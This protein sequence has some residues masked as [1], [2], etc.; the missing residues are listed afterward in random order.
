MAPPGRYSTVFSLVH[1]FATTPVLMPL[2][3]KL[4]NQAKSLDEMLQARRRQHRT[5]LSSL[6]KVQNAIGEIGGNAG[7]GGG[8][9]AGGGASAGALQAGADPDPDVAIAIAEQ[10]VSL[11]SNNRTLFTC[12]LCSAN[13]HTNGDPREWERGRGGGGRGFSSSYNVLSPIFSRY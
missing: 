5:L 4:T 8:G 10:I 3:G 13:K 12:P 6:A 7:G 9:G 1:V 11:A 2:L